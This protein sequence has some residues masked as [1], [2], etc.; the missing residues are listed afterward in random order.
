MIEEINIRNMQNFCDISDE[1]PAPK[2]DWDREYKLASEMA[3][4]DPRLE[5]GYH[6]YS[7]DPHT[8]DVIRAKYM[9]KAQKELADLTNLM[10]NIIP[11]NG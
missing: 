11:K 5:P 7:L 10:C 1:L 8:R 4:D 6:Q 9:L 3:D 2:I